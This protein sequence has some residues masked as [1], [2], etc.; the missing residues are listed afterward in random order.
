[1]VWN[2][3][4]EKWESVSIINGLVSGKIY[5]KTPYLMGKSMVS[6]R[7]SLKPIHWYYGWLCWCSCLFGWESVASFVHDFPWGS[8]V[9][10]ERTGPT[11]GPWR[12]TKSWRCPKKKCEHT[13]VS[14]QFLCFVL[15]WTF[16]HVWPFWEGC[17]IAR[18]HFFGSEL[19]DLEGRKISNLGNFLNQLGSQLPQVPLRRC[20]LTLAKGFFLYTDQVSNWVRHFGLQWQELTLRQIMYIL[21]L[22]STLLWSMKV[23]F[24]NQTPA[25]NTPYQPHAA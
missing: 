2:V 1:M 12:S 7:F 22:Y 21:Y 19:A 9:Q 23:R 3:D 18:S 20:R 13:K 8:T 5:R 15:F 14:G 24:M 11:P 6:C 17:Q 25:V 16:V 10:E 4:I